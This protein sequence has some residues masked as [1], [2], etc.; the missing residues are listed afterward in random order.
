MAETTSATDL[1]EVF[2]NL[3]RFETILWNTIDAR[4]RRDCGIP[5]GSFN[6]ML[7]VAATPSC[8]VYDIA[9]AL[10][11]TV[12]G[13]SQAVDRIEN[14]G[15]CLRRPNPDDRRSSILELTS[16]GQDLLAS[17]GIVFDQE[18]EAFLRAPLSTSAVGHL[19]AALAAVRAAA[20][21]RGTPAGHSDTSPQPEGA[22]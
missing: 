2:D 12:G 17:A 21:R 6:V 10:A 4:L 15:L 22:R 18:L 3:V 19:G 5:L 11:I 8:R 14:A 13:T 20:T 16:A 7:I 9:T 1:R